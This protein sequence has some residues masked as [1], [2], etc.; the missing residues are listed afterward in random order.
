MCPWSV[1]VETEIVAGHVNQFGQPVV[2]MG[3]FAFA[4]RER[5]DARDLHD[6]NQRPAACG[7]G[8]VILLEEI[9]QHVFEVAG[10]TEQRPD[11]TGENIIH[12]GTQSLRAEAARA[13]ALSRPR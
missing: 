4:G 9:G 3:Q 8:M 10:T 12:T 7:D 13:C 5:V 11:R 1:E 2:D 6:R